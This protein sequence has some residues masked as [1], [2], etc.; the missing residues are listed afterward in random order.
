MA[1]YYAQHPL[2]VQHN[3]ATL[4][5]Y[6]TP[7]CTHLIEQTGTAPFSGGVLTHAPKGLTPNLNR[8]KKQKGKNQAKAA[9]GSWQ[10][11]ATPGHFAGAGFQAQTRPTFLGSDR[12][13]EYVAEI[14]QLRTML[15]TPS[16]A[17]AFSLQ[18]HAY[19]A[20]NG[21]SAQRPRSHYCGLHGWSNDHNGTECRVMARDRIYTDAMWVA[22]MHVGTGGNPKVGVPV[23]FTRP[24]PH[25][26][27]PIASSKHCLVCPPSLSQDSSAK[28]AHTPYDDYSARAS[29]ASPRNISEGHN[30]SLVR[31]LAGAL[32]VSPVTTAVHVCLAPPA[33]L[34]VSALPVVPP[35]SRKTRS[36]SPKTR[37]LTPLTDIPNSKPRLGY[38]HRVT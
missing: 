11:S 31:E 30:A 8:R 6:L 23:W 16:T 3:I 26:F 7:Q 22:T 21:S 25:T 10:S 14:Q 13:V 35:L 29:P 28:L 12:E 2:I 24:P 15:A 20:Q 33:S 32:S 27:F 37:Q 38:P 1:G 9:W 18:Q 19:A 17:N 4:F 34:L 5:A 36:I